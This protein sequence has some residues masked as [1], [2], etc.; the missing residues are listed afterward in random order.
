[1]CSVTSVVG[2][3]HVG[4]HPPYN[5]ILKL[6]CPLKHSDC[7]AGNTYK[8]YIKQNIKSKAIIWLFKACCVLR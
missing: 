3:G 5:K 6:A 2:H 7:K 8:H 1:M 4:I